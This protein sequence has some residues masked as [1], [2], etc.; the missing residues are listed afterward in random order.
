[1]LS[2]LF[3]R[4]RAILTR[5]SMEAEL[6]EELRVHLEHETAK[7]VASG[8]SHE[9]A[10]RRA[11]LAI[12][13]LDQV[14]EDCRDARGVAW[15]ETI[16]ADLAYAIRGMRR[17]PV[18]SLAALLTLGLGVGALSTVFTIAN[19]L[20]FEALPAE[21][22]KQLVVVQATRRHG[23]ALGWVGYT[24]YAR[25]RDNSRTLSGLAAHYSTAP[26][27]VSLG[28]R[29]K[30]INGGVVSANFFPVLG[31]KPVLGR[32]F[33]PDEDRVPDRDRVAVISHGFWHTWFSAS[34]DAIGA[35]VKVNGTP[36]TV[37]GVTP[38]NFRGVNP[39][40][41]ELYLPAMMSRIGYRWCK[42][43]FAGDCTVFSMIGRLGDQFSSGQAGMEL[44]TLIPA[45]WG[46]AKDGENSG[47]MVLPARGVVDEDRPRG[48]QLRFVGLLG[49]V[50]CVLLLVCCVN[51]G[52]LMIAR[53]AGRVREFAIRFALGARSGRLIRQ[54]M[55]ESL[56]LGIGGGAVGLLVSTFL[57]G[58]LNAAF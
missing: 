37:V 52:G 3:F 43:P 30:E 20:L 19:T 42:D 55:T 41:V 57:T 14:K 38:E 29:A 23:Q 31:L 7:L 27:F 1:M 6:E 2:D 15:W 17:S 22:P 47:V 56:V 34:P 40:P 25:F 28:D 33:S 5:R 11:R 46:H 54:L 24:D 45:E 8:L 53:N 49:G 13:G 12:G 16:I 51:L 35:T 58:G 10:S 4:L 18:H 44:A 36:F 39:R 48:S 32:F 26:L 50:A 21:K 9:N